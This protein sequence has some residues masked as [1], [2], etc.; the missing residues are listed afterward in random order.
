MYLDMEQLKLKLKLQLA[1]LRLFIQL[2]RQA[3]LLLGP[4]LFNRC[5]SPI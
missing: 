2:A 3:E 5:G 1:D 4:A